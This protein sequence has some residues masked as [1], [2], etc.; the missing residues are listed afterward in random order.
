MQV[1]RH[2]DLTPPRQIIVGG[3]TCSGGG[4]GE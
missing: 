4:G 3:P 2:P 1:F